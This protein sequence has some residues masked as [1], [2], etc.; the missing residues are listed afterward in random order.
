[1]V[2]QVHLINCAEGP[3]PNLIPPVEVPRRGFQLIVREETARK[4]I[5]A[6]MVKYFCERQLN[7]VSINQTGIIRIIDLLEPHGL[8]NVG[9]CYLHDYREEKVFFSV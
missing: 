3:F 4:M 8:S 5:R 9:V 6:E 2:L 1:M 7:H